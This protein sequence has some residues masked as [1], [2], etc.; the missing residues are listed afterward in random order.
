MKEIGFIGL[1]RMGANMVRRLAEAGIRC[2]AHDANPAAVQA[3]RA[4]GITGAPTLEGFMAEL[5]SPRAIWLMVPAAVVEPV[6]ARL[7][8]LLAPATSSLTAATR[9]TAT[10]CAAARN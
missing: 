9:T 7:R 5:V 2:V 3:L 10:T 4:P 8:S 6:L 1:G